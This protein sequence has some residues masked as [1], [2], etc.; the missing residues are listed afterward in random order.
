MIHV[1]IFHRS[2][3]HVS[4]CYIPFCDESDRVE[5]IKRVFGEALATADVDDTSELI[6]LINSNK[7]SLVDKCMIVTVSFS[8][9]LVVSGKHGI[10][11]LEG[12]VQKL[13][14]L[15]KTAAFALAKM[16]VDEEEV[17]PKTLR[18]SVGEMKDFLKRK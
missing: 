8:T 6:N 11:I 13:D 1:K 15:K 5:E 12:L 2:G 16:D 14:T 10:I 4:P 3:F 7:S 17:L 18:R 9:F